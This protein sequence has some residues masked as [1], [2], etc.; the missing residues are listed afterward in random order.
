M[1]FHVTQTHAPETCPLG[2]GG[3]RALYNPT[4]E[5]VT[6]RAMYG[7]YAEH[8]IYYLVEADS[9][10]PIQQFLVPGFSRCSTTITPVIEEPVGD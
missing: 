6:L 3:S 8:V 10:G 4:A 2:E 7:A 1:L 5:G 9:L